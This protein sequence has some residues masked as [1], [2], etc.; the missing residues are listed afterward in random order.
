MANITG[1]IANDFLSGTAEADSILGFAGNDTLLGLAGDDTINGNEGNDSLLGDEQNDFL[2]GGQN[3]DELYG[4]LG[5]DTLFGDLGNDSVFGG[6][7]LDL[8]FGSDGNDVLNGN[9]GNDTL[10]GEEG[11]DY[12]RGGQDNDFLYGDLGND[13][14]YGDLG[15]DTI[16]GDENDDE[17]NGNEG[18]DVLNGN[19]GNDTVRG[20]M[21][22]DTVRGGMDND[23][24][25]GDL[26]DDT[27]FGDQG[28]DSVFGGDGTDLLFGNEGNDA[29]NGNMGN[30]T[31][32]GGEGNDTIRGGM[33]NDS[34]LGEVGNDTLYGDLGD[35][36]L[37][38]GLDNDLLYGDQGQESDFGGDG[39]DVLLGNEG[40]DSI[41][42]LGGNDQLFGN[43]NDDILNGNEGQDTVFG[44]MGDDLLRGGKGNDSLFG[45]RGRDTIFGD[46]GAD[47]LTGD[48]GG[49]M[50]TDV[51]VVG[52]GTGGPTRPDADIVTDFQLC[53]DLISLTGGVSYADLNITQGTG[54]DAAN[55]IITDKVTGEFLAVLQNTNSDSIDGA[56][57]IPRGSE[58][59]SITAINPTTIESTPTTA[60]GLFT[61][62]VPCD[63]DEDLKVNYTI[64]GIAINGSDYQTLSGSV[65][66]AA[67][68]NSAT[69]PVTAIDDAL[70]EPSETVIA[71][72]T[73]GTG[74]DIAAAKNTATVTILDND[75]TT[76]TTVN[77]FASDPLASEVG[78]DNGQFTFF[79]TGDTSG[80]LTVNYTL[81]PLSTATNITDYTANPVFTTS[82]ITI[83]A[84]STSATINI[85]PITDSV[86]EGNETI[87]LFLGSGTGYT[88]G[89]AN[90][91]TVIIQDPPVVTRPTVGVTAPDSTTKEAGSTPG[92]FQFSRT[93]G[94][95]TQPVTITYTISGTATPSGTGTPSD[96]DYS[97]LS[98]TSGTVTIPAGSSVSSLINI[99]ATKDRNEPT[100]T[101]TVTISD[102][103]AYFVGSQGSATL[104]ILDDDGFTGTPTN[105]LVLRY[106][107]AGAFQM[108]Y[109]TIAAAV[110]PAANN[111]II[112]VRSGM[113][114]ESVTIDKPLTIRGPNAGLSPSSGA[115]VTPAIVT[116][117]PT[118]PVFTINS[119]LS[120]VTIEG[121][122]IEG[123]ATAQNLI[124]YTSPTGNPNIVIRQNQ[125]I[126]TGPDNG[127]VIR[128]DF[129]GAASS[130]ATITDNLIRDIVSGS[131]TS[132]IQTFRI[133]TISIADN[134][135]SNLTGPGIAADSIT[136]ASS[137]INNNSVSN[138]NQ[139]GIQLAGGSA[140]IANNDITN[141]N[142]N[143]GADDGGI[144]L[145]N[146][147]FGGNLIS[148]NVF[149][150]TITNSF[151][152]VSI[153]NGDAITG[154]VTINNNN[155]IGNTNAGL[156]HGGTGA[157]DA[158][159][160]W[161]DSATGPVVGGTGRNAIN[162]SGASSVIFNPFA[163]Q[164]F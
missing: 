156:Y 151:N 95:I 122:T 163:T 93:G 149:G 118:Q 69:I 108:G 139:Q 40:N 41:F 161:W 43:E 117:T 131:V 103:S 106:N 86:I 88:P 78:P 50:N 56:A 132:A 76:A 155:L 79:R 16:L 97:G 28:N 68:A 11:Q 77:L 32:F 75:S 55:T 23:E 100:E 107:Q 126:G 130:S 14:L 120:G 60:T 146:S 70:V 27:V 85:T 147:G 33:N 116:G 58:K 30:D 83:P 82:T 59:V 94:D 66:I 6:E 113:Y 111:D 17:I 143:N 99:S 90:A 52:R 25:Y 121:L 152:G 63:V 7:G 158:K 8:L 127:G 135:I 20:G 71:T 54:A 35:D 3:N 29:L 39:N 1:T 102:N 37:Y 87:D 81:S 144:R 119:G 162:G 26:G 159:N 142:L 46:L 160:N 145:R 53:I 136:N 112:V 10:F 138:V 44:G 19:E 9:Q 45:D 101:V 140:T 110:T 42:G 67:G 38:G 62:S 61:V 65:T 124:Q 154:T 4:D 15:N 104:S 64:S 164:P 96:V 129:V 74:Y 141:V 80:A 5:N 24:L 51:F 125:F 92:T 128:L 12:L 137:V 73:S 105:D 84:G 49:E 98:G 47:T 134:T 115:G 18:E 89:P 21:D 13:S 150:N 91:A 2:R 153:R 133:N 109:N 48:S 72:L 31:A 157:I 36:S 34:L 114:T 148:A 123:K 57:F 22:N